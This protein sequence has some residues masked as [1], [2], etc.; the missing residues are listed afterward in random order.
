MRARILATGLGAACAASLLFAPSAFAS[1]RCVG[2]P[3]CYRTIQAALDASHDGDTI[4]IASGTFAGGVTV[5]RSVSI[6]GAG[7]GSTTIRGGG[8]VVTIG[9]FGAAS[10]PTVSL[11]AVKITGGRTTSTPDGMGGDFRASGGGVFVPPAA[12]F[13]AGATVTIRGS[14]IAGNT[15]APTKTLG[16]DPGQ[17][18]WPACPSGPCP[19]A[20]A[21]GAGISTWGSTTLIDT[22][23]SDNEAGGPVTSDA[24]GAGIWSNLGTLTLTRSK[25]LCN[26]AVVVAPNGRFAE[27]GGALVE[28]GALVMRDSVVAGNVVSLTSALPPSVGDTPIDMQSHAGGILVADGVPTTID[29]AL[30]TGN[31]AKARDLAGAP[32]AFDSA[33]QVNN[34]PLTMRDTVIKDNRVTGVTKTVSSNGPGGSAVELDGGGTLTRVQIVDN[35]SSITSPDGTA[36]VVGALGVFDFSGDPKPVVLVDSVVS[37]NRAVASTSTGTATSQGGGIF[38]NSLLELRRVVVSD[39]VA[40]ALGPDGVAEGGGI[41]NGVALSGPP[42]TLTLTDSLITRNALLGSPGIERHGGGLFT[43]EPVTLTRTKIAGNAP[44]QCFGCSP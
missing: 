18:D 7:A 6:K 44:D 15:A 28:G 34:S 40:K 13:A 38:N 37:G 19:F 26:R 32:V 22:V 21:D 20:G 5:T 25:L 31:E 3:G 43:T 41:W 33:L 36:A 24:S 16:P 9:T 10:E 4:K 12:D 23:V 17:T 29:H 14:A 27:G 2:G 42:V 35:P 30:F 39:N 11:E 1:K 8:P